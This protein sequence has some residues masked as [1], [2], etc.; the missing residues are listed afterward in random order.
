M[1]QRLQ[2]GRHNVL[3]YGK[4]AVRS[5]SMVRSHTMNA[6]FKRACCIIILQVIFVLPSYISVF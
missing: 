5:S 6:I 1:C 3:K 4:E 2:D